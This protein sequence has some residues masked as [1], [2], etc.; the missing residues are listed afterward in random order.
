M[1]TYFFLNFLNSI[2]F[3][4]GLSF[5]FEFFEFFEFKKFKKKVNTYFFL[6]FSIF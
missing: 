1:N 4:L 3:F 6:N 2:S 5:F